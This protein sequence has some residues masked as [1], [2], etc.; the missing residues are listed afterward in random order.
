PCTGVALVLLVVWLV[1]GLWAALVVSGASW[2]VWLQ[3]GCMGIGYQMCS[4]T[5]PGSLFP[6]IEAWP[7]RS[8]RGVCAVRLKQPGMRWVTYG[9][10][11]DTFFTQDRA[12]YTPPLA[13][14]L[15]PRRGVF[16]VSRTQWLFPLW[17][18]VFLAVFAAA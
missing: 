1:S 7:P 4:G 5:S 16:T 10:W 8:E 6:D 18:V 12:D 15:S 11:T 13:E 2:R 14:L 17:P 3:S 9:H